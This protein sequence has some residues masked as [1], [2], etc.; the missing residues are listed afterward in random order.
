MNLVDND[1]IG[2]DALVELTNAKFADVANGCF[3]DPGTRMIIKGNKIV[4]MLGLA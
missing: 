4:A 2:K 3:F 1:L